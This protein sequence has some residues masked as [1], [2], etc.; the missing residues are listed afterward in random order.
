ML[1]VSSHLNFYHEKL[2][3]QPLFVQRSIIA[4]TAEYQDKYHEPLR[5]RHG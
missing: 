3:L 1:L 5:L 4:D 2:C